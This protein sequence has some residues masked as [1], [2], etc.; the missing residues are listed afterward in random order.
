MILTNVPD[1]KPIYI[2]AGDKKRNPHRVFD[3]DFDARG[4]HPPESSD[5]Q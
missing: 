1:L 5:D 3:V 2:R 4:K